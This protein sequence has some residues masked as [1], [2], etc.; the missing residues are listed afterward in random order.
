[1][2]IFYSGRHKQEESLFEEMLQV[3]QA[4]VSDHDDTMLTVHALASHAVTCSYTE[5]LTMSLL[6]IIYA[7][8][9]H[10][11]GVVCCCRILIILST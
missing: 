10:L 6:F 4:V 8:I 3:S 9:L 5:E 1:M 2:A 11:I 7:P